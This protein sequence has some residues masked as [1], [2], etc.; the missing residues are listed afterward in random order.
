MIRYDALQYR[1]QIGYSKN[2]VNAKI[3]LTVLVFS[4]NQGFPILAFAEIP[5]DLIAIIESNSKLPL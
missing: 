1:L 2:L 4:H 5:E 3:A